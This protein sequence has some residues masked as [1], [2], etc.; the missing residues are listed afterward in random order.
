MASTDIRVKLIDETR[1]GFSRISG[2]MSTLQNSVGGLTRGFGGLGT[3]IAGAFTVRELVQVSSTFQDLRSSLN[4]LYGDIEKG[5]Q[6]FAEIKTFATES[7]FGIE[8]LTQTFIKL[9]AAGIEPTERLLNLFQDT[10]SVT[11]DSLGALQAVTDLFVRT[12]GGGLGLEELE[13]LADRGIPVYDI[14]REK[15]GLTRSE[16]SKVGQSAQGAQDILNA[17][18]V[19]LEERFGGAV[20]GRLN[21]TSVAMSNFKIA[22][23][24]A[25]D[26]IGEGGFNTA[27]AE[28]TVRL[29]KFIERNEELAKTLGENL[30][31]A[32]T[33]VADN[34][35]LLTSAFVGFFAVVTVGK[36]IALAEALQKL[37]LV[38]GKNLVLKVAAAVLSTVGAFN[39]LKEETVD[40]TTETEENTKAEEKNQEVKKKQAVTSSVVAENRAKEAQSLKEIGDTLRNNFE[41]MREELNLRGKQVKLTDEQIAIEEKL[42]DIKQS[43]T[44]SLIRLEKDYANKTADERERLKSTYEAEKQAIEEL[45]KQQ[46]IQ[47]QNSLQF[48]IQEERQRRLTLYSIDEQ[49]KLQNQLKDVRDSMATITMPTLERKIYDID[50]AARLSAKTQI[51]AEERLRNAKLTPEEVKEYYDAA[52]EGSEKLKQATIEEFEMSRTWATGWKQAMNQYVEDATNA[53]RQA[54]RIFQTTFRGLEDLIVDFTKTGK[55]E[56]KRFV[57]SIAEEMLRSDLRRLFAGIFGGG[58]TGGTGSLFAGFFANGGTI[59]GGQFGVVGERGPELVSGP[60]TVTPMSTGTTQVTYNINAVDAASFKQLVARDPEYIYAVTEQ[61]RKSLPRNRR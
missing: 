25:F 10:A 49:I 9:K 27:L 54:E 42:L 2:Q 15:L 40:L 44:E 53:A 4:V 21:N 58:N 34:A 55:F 36:I 6:A 8:E 12:T 31:K 41:K 30:G 61:G 23:N 5:N 22:V 28:T 47:V 45:G 46:A 51:E 60:A 18:Q 59:P 52:L 56:F 24:N 38:M 57:A 50:R 13:R 33:F 17:L 16:I 7:I 1:A 3:A 37:N 32:I 14:L 11:T 39:M 29:T 20:A 35:K 48:A 19:G 26:A 43:T